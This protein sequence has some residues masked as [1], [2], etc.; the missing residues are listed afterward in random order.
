MSKKPKKRKDRFSDPLKAQFIGHQYMDNSSLQM[1]RY[2]AEEY[3][4]IKDIDPANIPE[5]D[6][7]DTIFYWLNLHGIH[8]TE[9]VTKIC[10]MVGAHRLVVQDIVDTTERTKVQEF[11]NHLFFTIRSVF[12]NV[13]KLELENEKISFLLGKNY[14]ISFQEKKGDY[15]E[16]IRQRIRENKGLSRQ[17][18]SDYLLF[19]LLDAILNNYFNVIDS[20][21]HV[22]SAV[23]V[24][25]LI[26]KSDPEMII[27]FENQKVQLREVKSY[28]L[29][30]FDSVQLLEDGDSEF[31][32][33]PH[34]K[35]F[36]DLKEQCLQVKD[37]IE[38]LIQKLESMSALYFSLQ[39]HRAN[40]IMKTLTIVA[41]IFIPLSFIAGLYGMNFEH[42]PELGY[43]Y[44][45]FILLGVMASV[46]IGMLLYFKRKKW[47]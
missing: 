6:P 18:S 17:R 36:F 38:S 21:D 13:D 26:K 10:S 14:V 19:L 24:S 35:Y 5:I 9:L 42:M 3:T 44:S 29:P 40:E 33:P 12:Y 2:N 7:N 4:E 32:K 37:H 15:F 27:G 28:I 1:F 16:Y 34:T 11:D 23:P 41:G 8:D 20:I 30:F 43:K 46:A 25:E 47:F 45:Y 31:I 22:V 39:G